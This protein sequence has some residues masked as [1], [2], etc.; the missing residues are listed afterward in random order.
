LKKELIKNSLK[1]P[2]SGWV[3][4]VLDKNNDL[5]IIS[6]FNQDGPW[7]LHLRPLIAIDVWE[8]AYYLDYKASREE[9]VKKLVN[10][11]LNW[12]YINQLYLDYYFNSIG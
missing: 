6:T 10:Y 8:H 4:L 5:K 7:S 12:E 9:Y 11:L 1:I 3:W 2:G